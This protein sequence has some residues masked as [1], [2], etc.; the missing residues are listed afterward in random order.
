MQSISVNGQTLAIDPS[1]F[2]TSSSQGTIIDS[3]TTLAYLAEAAYDPFISAVS[4]KGILYG[5]ID[6]A[7]LR[8]STNHLFRMMTLSCFAGKHL[9]NFVEL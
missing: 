1:V 3:G 6:W 7:L 2:G 8:I 9:R 5:L 4:F